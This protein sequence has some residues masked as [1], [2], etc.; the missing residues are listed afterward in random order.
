MDA[1]DDSVV[2]QGATVTPVVGASVD[3]DLSQLDSVIS[4]SNVKADNPA[5]PTGTG[6]SDSIGFTPW[7]LLQ[8]GGNLVS[9]HSKSVTLVCTVLVSVITIVLSVR[10]VQTSRENFRIEMAAQARSTSALLFNDY[11]NELRVNYPDAHKGGELDAAAAQFLGA[12]TQFILNGV[13]D[14]KFRAEILTFLGVTRLSAMLKPTLSAG[15]IEA[16][17]SLDGMSFD[18]GTIRGDFQEGLFA[19]NSFRNVTLDNVAFSKASLQYTDFSGSTISQGSFAGSELR[20]VSLA[21]VQI[22]ARMPSFKGAKIHHTDLRGLSI[23]KD[24]IA[25]DG[26]SAEESQKE[27][28]LAGIFDGAEFNNVLMDA[29]VALH[30]NE[31]QREQ[32]VTD[33]SMGYEQWINHMK[34]TRHCN[35]IQ[36]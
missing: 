2:R 1:S 34:G 26:N 14:H 20:C 30:L 31:V 17:L 15:K 28:L 10:E 3:A 7:S 23:S 33:N 5:A 12:Q 27:R 19:W 36:S 29:E 16:P 22:V 8:I 6:R 21:N 24:I 9:K 11:L 18:D 13:S 32:V 4:G 35:N 25:T